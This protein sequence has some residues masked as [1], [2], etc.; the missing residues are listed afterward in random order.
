MI[1]AKMI[2]DSYYDFDN[3]ICTLQL[4]YPRFIH[5]EFMKNSE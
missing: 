4:K 5:A 2:A 1:T 3:R